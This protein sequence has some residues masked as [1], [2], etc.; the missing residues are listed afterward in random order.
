VVLTVSFVNWWNRCDKN[1]W[2]KVNK[3]RSAIV[4]VKR[5]NIEEGV[6][7]PVR[8]GD[9]TDLEG[10]IEWPHVPSTGSNPGKSNRAMGC[11][12]GF[13]RRRP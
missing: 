13:V 8:R 12:L 2:K 10:D 4:K 5:C 1:R 6:E 9:G 7:K 11:S 3:L